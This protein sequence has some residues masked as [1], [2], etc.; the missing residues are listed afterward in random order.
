LAR[1]DVDT[2]SCPCRSVNELE[3]ILDVIEPEEFVKVMG[4]L[5]SN[6]FS[7]LSACVGSAHFQVAER[8]LYFWNNEYLMSLVHENSKSVIPLV[9]PTLYKTSKTH[10]NKAIHSLVFAALKVFASMNQPLCDDRST[11]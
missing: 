11:K 3:E 10:W 8:A 5:F 6:L 7:K 9:F 4:P 2:A 1:S